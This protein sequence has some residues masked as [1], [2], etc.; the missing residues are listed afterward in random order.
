MMMMMTMMIFLTYLIGLIIL[1]E[2]YLWYDLF[3]CEN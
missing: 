2:R 1:D 3:H